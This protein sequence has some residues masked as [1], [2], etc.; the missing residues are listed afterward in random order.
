MLVGFEA[1]LTLEFLIKMEKI[2]N[3]LTLR[4]EINHA[5]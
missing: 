5:Y 2:F 1:Q 4:E 3:I